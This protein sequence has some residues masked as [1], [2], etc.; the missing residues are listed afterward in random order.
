VSTLDRYLAG[1]FV[2]LFAM[3]ASVFI[4]L[5]TLVS[6]FERLETFLKHK[7]TFAQCALYLIAQAPFMLVQVMPMACLL[8]TLVALTLMSRASETTAL[9]AVG[10]SLIRIS[11]PFVLCGAVVCVL[12]LAL[13]EIVI[14][15]TT[16]FAEHMLRVNIRGY[17]ENLLT[18]SSDVWMRNGPNW[19]FVKL[20]LPSAGE[21]R[22]VDVF[23]TKD[24]K[25]VRQLKAPIAKWQ[26]DSWALKKA[27]D[28]SFD[29][30]GWQET[31]HKGWLK[32][33][34]APKPENLDYEQARRG[35]ASMGE[36]KRR[37]RSYTAQG[38]DTKNLEVQWWA[39]TSLPFACVLMPLLAVPFGLRSSRRGG[40]W[41][42]IGVA[43]A[44]SFVYLLI[45]ML[46][47]ALG[48]GGYLA[49]WL[50]A[51]SGN[52]VF[53]A[54]AVALFRRAEQGN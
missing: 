27:Y 11:R 52:F 44:V 25:V 38:L 35:T 6:L 31:K 4:G 12:T 41:T 46:G 8:S 54:I 51:W 24:G 19:V 45:L 47:S 5:F 14:P 10:L 16:A 40:M 53:L 1:Q 36:L 33:P 2:R 21:L 20:A 50:S 7:A 49:P 3:C 23:E 34:I 22:E 29:G 39:L 15:K 9:R 48:Q 13:Q 43:V 32:L 30:N 26:G 17:P 18:H 42:S 37:I 28:V